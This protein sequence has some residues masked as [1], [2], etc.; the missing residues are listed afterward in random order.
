SDP[1][2][3]GIH[4]DDDPSFPWGFL[5][6]W[7]KPTGPRFGG[8]NGDGALDVGGRRPNHRGGLPVRH[9]RDPRHGVAHRGVVRRDLAARRAWRQPDEGGLARDPDRA[10]PGR[11]Q[12]GDTDRA[13]QQ[14]G[15]P[16]PREGPRPAGS[17]A[18]TFAVQRGKARRG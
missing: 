5:L 16:K 11:P 3:N 14:T 15:G 17:S 2:R 7:R 6:Y 12:R 10:R 9:R 1:T 13:G 4:P 18:V 8:E